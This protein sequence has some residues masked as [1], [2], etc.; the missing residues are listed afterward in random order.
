MKSVRANGIDIA[1]EDR[2]SG[3]PLLLL[4]GFPQDHTL[5]DAQAEALESKYRLLIPDLR[6][7]GGTKHPAPGDPISMEQLADDAA[8][9][10]E[11]VDISSAAVAGWSLGG[12]TLFEMA[13]RYP[14][15]VRA[16][17]FVSTRAAADPPGREEARI[18]AMR[19]VVDEGSGAFANAFLPQL[20]SAPFL[21]A[22]PE[23]GERTRQVI[24]S[25]DPVSIAMTV[26]A[27]RRKEDM[28]PRLHE[29]ACPCA[30]ISGK[31]DALISYTLMEAVHAGLPDSTIDIIEGA[32]HMTTVEA[33]DRVTFGLDSLMQ[34]AGM[35]M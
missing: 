17:A 32:G 5:W 30:V 21:A 11:A 16:A 33:P 25:Q 12:F 19:F 3:P 34:R 10:L 23:A 29:I 7:H 9:F 22:N 26:D 28:T 6:G 15:K 13:V 31:E 18:K 14:L 4:H 1:Y 20:Y 35:W 27:I 2:G 8:A 24:A